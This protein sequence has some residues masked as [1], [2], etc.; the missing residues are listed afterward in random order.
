MGKVKCLARG[1][2]ALPEPGLAPLPACQEI[3]AGLGSLRS[4]ISTAH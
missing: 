2:K 1:K 4:L 3:R